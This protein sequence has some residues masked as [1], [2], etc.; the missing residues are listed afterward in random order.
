MAI[1]PK[2]MTPSITVTETPFTL[3]VIPSPSPRV[4]PI[5]VSAF[6]IPP[7]ETLPQNN[8]AAFTP[9]VPMNFPS[10]KIT[11]EL[12]KE[13]ILIDSSII[14]IPKSPK[15]TRPPSPPKPTKEELK[16]KAQLEK[17]KKLLELKVRLYFNIWR[18]NVKYKI[19]Q[20]KIQEQVTING[21][22]LYR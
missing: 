4:T 14:T 18:S 2:P 15:I 12:S 9:E 19:Q 16:L 20:R 1:S 3:P 6:N 10:P 11:K 22:S 21:R 17:H 5:S 13:K 8:F 7:N